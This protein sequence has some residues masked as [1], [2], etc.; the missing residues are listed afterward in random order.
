MSG[1]EGGADRIAD[2]ATDRARASVLVRVPPAE[3]FTLF[4]AH[5][6]AWWKRGMRFRHGGT[7]GLV[8]LEPHLGGRLFE[9]FDH[10]PGL[11]GGAGSTGEH[12][13]EV[14]RVLAW[15]PPE[16]LVFSWRNAAFTP[17]QSTTVEVRFRPAGGGTQV[18]VEHRGWNGIPPDHPVRHGQATSEFLRTMGLWWGEQLMSLRSLARRPAA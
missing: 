17:Q 2:D 18:E 11:R 10:G 6:D 12:I 1:R 15:E 5:I 14:G 7:R 13:V 9:S 4:T 8:H 16:R 3:A